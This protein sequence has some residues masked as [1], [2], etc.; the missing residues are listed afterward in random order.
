MPPSKLL[1]IFSL[2]VVM[3]AGEVE[4]VAYQFMMNLGRGVE[5]DPEEFDAVA[6]VIPA[7]KVGQDQS[8]NIKVQ[9]LHC[10][11]SSSG[12]WSQCW[13]ASTPRTWTLAGSGRRSRTSTTSSSSTSS[14]RL[15]E[16]NS[17]VFNDIKTG[18]RW[19]CVVVAKYF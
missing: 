6:A 1:P 10:R 12:S 14:K 5:W 17:T 15:V 13:R 9:T 3:A 16:L 11:S 8:K 2:Q 18:F 19:R 7:F 4:N